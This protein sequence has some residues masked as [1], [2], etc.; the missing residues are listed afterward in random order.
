MAAYRSELLSSQK[1]EYTWGKDHPVQVIHAQ[2]HGQK[3]G[4]AEFLT[5]RFEYQSGQVL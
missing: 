1:Q 2:I 5:D 3:Y 4:W